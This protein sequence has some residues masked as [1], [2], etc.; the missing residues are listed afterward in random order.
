V[1]NKNLRGFALFVLFL[2]VFTVFVILIYSSS[3]VASSCWEYTS[4]STCTTGNGCLW[5][6]DS[7]GSWCSEL[8]CW[9]FNTQN[10]CTTT[11]VPGKNCTW[12]S[13]STYN[14]CSELNCWSFSGTNQNT[15][16]NNAAGRSCTWSGSCYSVGGMG[17]YDYS[18][19]STC[20]NTTGCAWGQC[21]TKGCWSYTNQSTC[22]SAKDP[23]NGNN[24]TWSSS[25]NWCQSNYCGNYYNSTSC[26]SA[27]GI[28][29]E[30]SNYGYCQEKTCSGFNNQTACQGANTTISKDCRWTGSFCEEDSC[31]K[32]DKNQSGCGEKSKCVWSSYTSTGWCE[33]INCWSWDESKGGS[34]SA[35]QGNAT[36]YGL[37]CNWRTSSYGN[38][39]ER[40]YSSVSC[41][42]K[43][44]ERDCQDTY[45]CWWEFNNMN[46]PSAGGT[47]KT[48]TWGTGS[49]E[50]ISG[51]ILND[52][53]PGC[54]TFDNNQTEC[55][56]IMG[57]NFTS[58]NDCRSVNAGDFVLQGTN[59]TSDGIKCSYINDSNLCNSISVLSSCCSWQN[60]T[61]SDNKFSS[62]CWNSLAQTPNGENSC[63]EA[64]TQA[65]CD[66][67]A[68]TPWYWPCKW[69][70]SSSTAKCTV[71]EENIWGNRTKSLVSIENRQTCEA[72]GGKWVTENYC[73]GNVSIPTGRC[74]YKFN[75][76]TNCNKACFACEFKSDGS[77]YNS[78]SDAKS[79]C[80]GSNLGT[81]EFNNNTAAPNGF[82]FCE[83]KNEFKKGVAGNCDS[84]CGTCTYKGD[85]NGI[86][87]TTTPKNYC[88]GSKANSDGG[89]C[90]WIVD[91]STTTGGYCLKKGEKT[92]LDACDR[93]ATRDD[94][95][96]IGRT[97][98]ANFSGS[99]KWQG[100][101]NDGSC[102]A[103]VAEDVEICWNGEDDDGDGLSDC[104]D[105]GCYSDT[106]CGFVSGDCFNWNDNATC[107]ANECEWINDN[108]G[109]WCDFKGASCWKYDSNESTCSINSNCAWNNGT[110]SGWCE[111]DWSVAE[112]CF[113][114]T[115][116]SACT[117]VSNCV[118]TNDTWCDGNGANSDWCSNYGGWCNHEDFAPKNCWQ[119]SDKNIC[120]NSTGCAWRVDT[121][122]KPYCE[123][124]W[125]GNC[126]NY[127]SQNSCNAKS[128]CSWRTDSW[129]SWCDNKFGQC[130]SQT[131]ENTC[132]TITAVNCTWKSYGGG[133]GT[134]EPSCYGQ[135]SENSCTSLTGCIWKADSGWCEEQQSAAC[136]N[137]T[138]Y[139]NQTAC[140]TIS[141][142]EWN[143]PGWCNP[144]D[145]FSSGAIAGGGGGGGG[146]SGAE[147]Y[148][149]DGNKTL[150]ID[151]NIINISCGW[152]D[153]YDPGCEVNWARDC[154]QY[155]GSG[156]LGCNTTNGCW[157]NP[158]GGNGGWCG[159][160]VDQ[161][162]NNITLVNNA[163]ACNANSYCNSTLYGC[164]PTCFSQGTQ[165]ACTTVSNNT[166]RWTTGWCNPSG[167]NDVFTGI[168]AG[169]P[170]SL[171][172]DVCDLS[173]TNQSS[174]DLC[175]IGMKD[176]GNAYGF[177][178]NVRDYLQN[179][180]ICNKQELRDN[181]IGSGNETL[182]LVV[183]L[184]T[185]GSSSEGCEL[186][187]N[188]SAKGYE[189]KLR[190]SSEWN[191]NTSKAGETSTSYKC[192]NSKWKV[193]DV[194]ISTWKKIM[195]FDIGGPM[196]AV[197]KGELSRFPT[198]YDSTEDIRV[199][200]VTIGNTGNISSPTDKVGP[201]YATPGSI[202]FSVSGAFEFGAD[203]SKFEDILKNG[204]VQYEDCFNSVDDDN[205]QNIDCSDW[206]CQ[207]NPIC[208]GL[209]VNAD[210][211][212]D[213][214]MPEV[215]GVKIEEYYDSA[216]II[217]DTN[218]PSNGTFEFYNNDSRCSTLNASIFDIG[219]ISSNVRNY[220]L[221]H[222]ADIYSA[223]LG[224]SLQNDTT[225][226]YRIK[227]CDDTNKCAISKCSTFVTSSRTKC[228]FCNFVTRIKTSSDWEVLYDV[229]QD[230]TYEHSQG[231]VCGQNAGMKSNHTMR[232]VNI[233][234]S[235]SD[236]STYFEF[237]NASLTKT[238]LNDKV[239]SISG[240]EAII[241]SSNLVGLT[242]ETR[243]KIINN[244]HPEVCRIKI[245][246][247]S[248]SSLFHCDDSGS[249]CVDRTSE[250][251]LIDSSNCVWQIPYC[252]FS[253]YRTTLSSGSSGS[254]N[255]G[256]GGGGGGAGIVKKTNVTAGNTETEDD[257]AG[258]DG[259]A[260]EGKADEGIISEELANKI[261]LSMKIIIPVIAVGLVLMGL[262]TY[263]KLIPAFRFN[264]FRK[265]V[266]VRQG[267]D[268][269]I[270]IVFV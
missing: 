223:N 73:E 135:I 265:K 247:S 86:N 120:N 173:E 125:S 12:Q 101:D 180:S 7:W 28:N 4:S 83:T 254:S 31:W 154:W 80:L 139:S 74:E 41:S 183:Y 19:Q 225:Y 117:T 172:N 266:K 169:A 78:S 232:N 24:C 192:E 43:T 258:D 241:G 264:Q 240:S 210:N 114:L 235:K 255:N 32:Y 29:C 116:V 62:S 188:E 231:E 168:E 15:C 217:Y 94:C 48:P 256:G 261:K 171:A 164:E 163:S 105:P 249:N 58:S 212:T 65:N 36:L 77:S 203:G 244:L 228:G 26:T 174:A 184:D 170:T 257:N 176:M 187:H 123:V 215:T 218:K 56:K 134:C 236:G 82:G 211:Y 128:D 146:N 230:G 219:I 132:N 107:L 191:S 87:G 166:C 143:N 226:Y 53:N 252:E 152:T 25:N 95:S 103:N 55:N 2:T 61:C 157:W 49:F 67:L 126:W 205:D 63:E 270:K 17:C 153:D 136:Y 189:F 142:C 138:S 248:C 76:E 181:T 161:C 57:C 81:C 51:S 92:C 204:F 201:G 137:A 8:N 206:D 33:E 64:T 162:W 251:T 39:C 14:Y 54:Y 70:N 200:I 253:T 233:K 199:Y 144:K 150:C 110:G 35:C 115:N 149:Y 99:C 179:S 46:N 37:S 185:D 267:K 243:D 221:W 91:N 50:N 10:S 238:G 245:T 122:S 75:D 111:R 96:N 131:S 208:D 202:D 145:G 60:S 151:K 21:Q 11:N 121:W 71:K 18:T 89:G 13:G 59:I 118:W 66:K 3:V 239:R 68:Q 45:Y 84:D 42:N 197:E 6:N 22:G 250:A 156:A 100:S 133:G 224:F 234:L 227:V 195:C 207:F 216:L 27:I 177:G 20:Q 246:S 109:S 190:Y 268:I 104:F 130:W 102:A 9:S 182:K 16:E 119:S 40:D 263:F 242:S 23:W 34:Q 260:D 97:G 194:K 88:E 90:K 220:K 165:S 158:E 159:N 193:S 52:W 155:T 127:T 108:W 98:I 262:L 175:G 213:T 237:I 1:S 124:N 167:V 259:K 47:C 160:I 5:K 69:D 178:G 79:A 113:G 186:D 44:T 269:I 222:K 106:F 72:V 141:G 209:G 93:C 147:C 38:W 85:P 112:K 140:Q 214:K 148:K 30:W 196:I 129:G 229:N 198:L